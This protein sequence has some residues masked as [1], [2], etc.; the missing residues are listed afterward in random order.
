L[1]NLGAVL[2]DGGNPHEALKYLTDAYSTLHKYLGPEHTATTNSKKWLEKAI[3][4]S[5]QKPRK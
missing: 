3:S 4:M 2:V 5:N 1:L